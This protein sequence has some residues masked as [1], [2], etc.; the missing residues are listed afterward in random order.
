M[1]SNF[2]HLCWS[3]AS[4]SASFSD[5]G[6]SSCREPFLY[7]G[8]GWA[9]EWNT[10]LISLSLGVLKRWPSHSQRLLCTIRSM[11]PPNPS[12]RAVCPSVLKIYCAQ[13]RL[14]WSCITIYFQI[15][16]KAS[17]W[18]STN[19]QQ[20]ST[21]FILHPLHNLYIDPHNIHFRVSLQPSQ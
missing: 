11:S 20:C 10:W 17:A 15:L 9:L 1:S 19:C 5:H 7:G 6:H 8:C 21:Y 16:A 2:S 4:I 13:W 18:F 12:Q 14:W 3:F